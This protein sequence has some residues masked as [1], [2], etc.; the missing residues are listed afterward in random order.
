MMPAAKETVLVFAALREGDLLVVD[1]FSKL[2][3][4]F[5]DSYLQRTF[6]RGSRFAGILLRRGAVFREDHQF[7]RAIVGGNHDPLR[8]CMNIFS[9]FLLAASSSAESPLY[10]ML[11]P[12]TF[13]SGSVSSHSTGRAETAR[14]SATSKFSPILRVL[15]CVFCAGVG[16]LRRELQFLQNRFQKHEP[17]L[18]AIDQS[19]F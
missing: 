8:R 14:V 4:R 6:R 2:S 12:P 7:P 11:L 16:K 13:T 9:A 3:L 18:Q 5:P 1:F 10:A 17:L 15:P 19:G